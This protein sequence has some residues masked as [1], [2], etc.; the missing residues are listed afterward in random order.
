MGH[1][2][3]S[4]RGFLTAAGTLTL[5]AA[6]AGC[7]GT[8]PSGE[9]GVV[10]YSA[11]GLGDWFERQFEAFRERTGVAVSIV[12]GGSGEVI[13]RAAKEISNPQVD[14]IVTLPPFIQKAAQDDLLAPHGID[15]SI[16]DPED[17]D[18]EGLFFSVVRNY[19]TM[20]RSPQGAAPETWEDLLREDL[21]KKI[22]YST[23]GQSGDGT[24]MLLLLQQVLGRE[25]AHEYLGRLQANNVGP[26]SSTGRLGPKVSTGE[27]LVANSDV[28][29]AL[30][31]IEAERMDY[32][33]F[34]P[35]HAG[36]RTTV[37]LPYAM[38][39]AKNAPHA[40]GARRL[41]EFLVSAE[42]Q[43]SLPSAA[44]GE[45]AR[46]DVVHEGPDAERIAA[47]LDGAEIWSPDWNDVLTHL[48]S[49]LRDYREATQ[50]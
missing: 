18:A 17:R 20:I 1:H 36:G 10:V 25:E 31:A 34:I 44:R 38:G 41:M 27:L 8:G 43:Q 2:P 23:P 40:D 7:G 30:N 9:D 6:L 33:T 13:A 50:Q 5:G 45:S 15:V 47:A 14:L 48:D 37:A 49:D 11:D 46:R 35:A 22:Q 4:R 12:E 24:A 3:L 28:Q 19:F 29:M 16:L 42:V 32:E 39:L 26:S 21:R